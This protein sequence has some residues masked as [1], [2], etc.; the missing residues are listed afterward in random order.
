MVV[1]VADE[2]Q[3]TFIRSSAAREILHVPRKPVERI[4][5][6]VDVEVPG[7]EHL[8]IGEVRPSNKFLVLPVYCGARLL[9]KLG[10]QVLEFSRSTLG[11]ILHD[12]ES[13]HDFFAVFLVGTRF[14]PVEVPVVGLLR[15]DTREYP[16]S[17]NAGTSD[18]ICVW[19]LF[20]RV[21]ELL[22][23]VSGREQDGRDAIRWRNCQCGTGSPSAGASSGSAPVETS[24]TVSLAMSSSAAIA[25]AT[26]TTSQIEASNP[27]AAAATSTSQTAVASGTILPSPSSNSTSNATQSAVPTGQEEFAGA[28]VKFGS[29]AGIIMLA[30]FMVSLQ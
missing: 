3:S 20:A 21:R 25:V 10:L 28:G 2:A 16:G 24:A 12:V 29:H 15:T 30:A 6:V 4:F 23:V 7:F 13:D 19:I 11:Q 14:V 27:V 17:F 1:G 18:L 5:H 9:W 8:S 26:E 22:S